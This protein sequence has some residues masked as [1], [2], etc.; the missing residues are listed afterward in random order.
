MRWIRPADDLVRMIHS[1][2]DQRTDTEG[3]ALGVDFVVPRRLSL[4]P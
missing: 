2:I 1:S 3:L 4:E